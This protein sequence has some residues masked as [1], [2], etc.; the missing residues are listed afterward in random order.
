M[1]TY[2]QSEPV[3]K[4]QIHNGCTPLIPK[5][6]IYIYIVYIY[7]YKQVQVQVQYY[8]IIISQ[9]F[10]LNFIEAHTQRENT[11]KTQQRHIIR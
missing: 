2:K 11:K 3:T 7:I 5:R 9:V 10:C 8:D 1:F 4:Y 6:F